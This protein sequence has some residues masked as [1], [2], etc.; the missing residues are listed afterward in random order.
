[1][2]A[3]AFRDVRMLSDA[4]F[5]DE[6]F[7]GVEDMYCELLLRS[8]NSLLKRG[9][10][11]TTQN[12]VE[13]PSRP[14]GRINFPQ[15]IRCRVRGDR[16]LVCEYDVT[17]RDTYLN[18]ILKTALCSLENCEIEQNRKRGLRRTI[19]R[20]FEVGALD[21]KKIEWPDQ[22]PRSLEWYRIPIELSRLVLMHR[23]QSDG[24]SSVMAGLVDSLT[25]P[26][27]FE[28]FVFEY[29][30]REHREWAVSAPYIKWDIDDES[31][32]YLPIMKTDITLQR[33]R[34]SL[35][36]DTKYYENAMQEH[37][38]SVSQRSTN[39]YQ[40]Y[41]YVKNYRAFRPAHEKVSGLLLY[42]KTDESTLP[43]Q[44]YSISGNEIGVRTVDLS[45]CF[46][47]IRKELDEIP[48][49]YLS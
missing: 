47:D 22:Y 19:S 18:A 24:G 6:A 49:R 42:A 12:C 41:T 29:Y 1:M 9:L 40:I 14:R 7:S 33:A 2:L 4:A 35:I 13:K 43:D 11:T 46:D 36:V 21:P 48:K 5:G 17:S 23:I 8:A 34:R 15:S 30:R 10:E 27:L 37:F 32:D 44:F 39:L 20:F 25:M 16:S 28:R 26:R 45:A 31:T 3:Y 38:G